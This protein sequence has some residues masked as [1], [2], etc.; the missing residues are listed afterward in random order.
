TL[1]ETV[2]QVARVPLNI[3]GGTAVKVFTFVLPLIFV[4]HVPSRALMSLV[5]PFTVAVGFTMAAVLMFVSSR[6]WHYAT[7]FYASASS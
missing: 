4:A 5:Q 3:F 1:G 7:R 2:F 6:F